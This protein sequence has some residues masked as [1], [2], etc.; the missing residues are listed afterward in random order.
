LASKGLVSGKL[1]DAVTLRMGLSSMTDI[2]SL[3]IHETLK[4]KDV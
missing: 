3:T 2:Q 1:I 4:G